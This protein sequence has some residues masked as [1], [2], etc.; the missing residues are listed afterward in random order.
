MTNDE[1]ER[2]AFECWF[3]PR[4]KAM[5]A[6]GLGLISI[7]R[8][9]QRQWEAWRASRASLVID[10]YD[11]DQFSPNDSGEWAIWKTEV[12]RLIRKAGISVKEDE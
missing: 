5:K 6:Q 11:F 1:L 8:L 9:K 7:N 10:L 2:Q 12:A 3:E 4:Q